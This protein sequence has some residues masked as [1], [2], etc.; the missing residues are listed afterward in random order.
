[1]RTSFFALIALI[2]VLSPIRPAIGQTTQPAGKVNERLM[3]VLQVAGTA[4]PL[5]MIRV[6]DKVI[7]LVD[8]P[9][10]SWRGGNGKK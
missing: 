8:G 1:M 6:R 5:E 10:Q 2:T 4:R 7:T 9:V 3:R